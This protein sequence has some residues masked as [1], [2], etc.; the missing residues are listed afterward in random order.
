MIIPINQIKFIRVLS[1]KSVYGVIWEIQYANRKYAAKMLI[2][3]EEPANQWDK[4]EVQLDNIEFNEPTLPFPLHKYHKKRP[5]TPKEFNK[6]ISGLIYV[7]KYGPTYQGHCI[8]PES[9]NSHGSKL[10]FIIMNLVHTDL[11]EIL[12]NRPLS[13]EEDH[14]VSHLIKKI[15]R[16]LI[17]NDLK[18]ANIG[19]YLENNKISKAVLLDCGK[20]VKREDISPHKFM[21]KVQN[22]YKHYLYRYKR[23]VAE[24]DRL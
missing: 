19:L 3:K 24:R 2:I 14:I 4:H 23:N 22:E 16:K 5:I 1:T 11:E 12:R 10:G 21:T 6:E 13:K 9:A 8:W 18:P 15:H 20:I 17:H 7:D